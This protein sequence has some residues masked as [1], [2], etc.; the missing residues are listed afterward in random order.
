MKTT[1][2]TALLMAATQALTLNTEASSYA[3][4]AEYDDGSGSFN[5]TQQYPAEDD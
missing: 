4:V 2:A 5:K 3:L 1:L